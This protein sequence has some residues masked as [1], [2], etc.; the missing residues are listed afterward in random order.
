M[1]DKAEKQLDDCRD[2]IDKI[3]HQI[4]ELLGERLKVA[5]S[6]AEIKQSLSTPAY[7]RPE[8]EAQILG[9]LQ[10]LKSACL[11]DQD[12][13]SLFRV[14]MSITRNSESRLSVALLGPAG[15][16]S[17]VAARQHF[18][19]AM[20]IVYVP[21]V[22]DI[23]RS[24]ECGATDFALV[25]VDHFPGLGDISVFDQLAYTPLLICAEIILPIRHQL[26]AAVSSLKEV[27]SVVAHPQALAACQ[28]WINRHLPQS[29]LIS[30]QNDAESIRLVAESSHRAALV[31]EE[32]ANH[33]DLVVLAA[34]IQQDP[35]RFL[36]FLVLSTRD[37]PP[38]GN[39]RTTFVLITH[40]PDT[41]LHALKAMDEHKVSI[42]EISAQPFRK[43]GHE[44]FRIHLDV[45][46]HWQDAGV[47]EAM[48]KMKG[49]GLC[50]CLG[51]YPAAFCRTA[52][53]H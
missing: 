7:Y 32:V 31:Q 48:K 3:D 6:I 38:S 33:S 27:R 50:R 40:N 44:E 19:S 8:R 22:T 13:E 47:S 18:G 25:P 41:L 49:H 46:G 43:G 35:L 2:R 15:S 52:G 37:T 1:S 17:E 23:V 28:H 39:D 14:I 16:R 11:S 5:S 29:R 53:E 24:T 51:S 10:K 26:L 21:T 4:L 20:E 12:V 9:R 36:R 42:T 45:K 34:D 30:S